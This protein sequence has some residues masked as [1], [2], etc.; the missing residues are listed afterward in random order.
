MTQYV[1]ANNVNTQLAATAS[2][3]STTLTLASSTNLPTLSAGQIMPLTLNDAATGQNYEIVYVTAITG[4]TLTVVRAQEGTGALTWNVGDYAFCGPTANTVATSQGNP[5]NLFQVAAATAS[6]DAVNLGQFPALLAANGYFTV[7][8][9]VSGV[10][11]NAILQWGQAITPAS[12]SVLVTFPIAFP[13]A[14]LSA[15]ATNI[16]ASPTTGANGWA[17]V[18]TVT[19]TSMY[20]GLTSAS[21]TLSTAGGTSYWYAIGW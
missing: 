11:R 9:L 20:V 17:G 14:I 12:A 19:R 13:N 21:G 2:S 3:S 6:A 16:Q 10:Q 8:V 4:V 18:S 5:S 15:V 1:I 7:P